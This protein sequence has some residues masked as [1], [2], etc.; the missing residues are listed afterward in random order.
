[1]E[2]RSRGGAVQCRH[3]VVW[4]N[5]ARRRLRPLRL[6]PQDE[7]EY[8]ANGKKVGTRAYERYE[9]YKG[10][11]T[12]EEARQRGALRIDFCHDLRRGYLVIT[13]RAARGTA[14][15]DAVL[16]VATPQQKRKNDQYHHHAPGLPHLRDS[17]RITYRTNRKRPGSLAYDRYEAYRGAKTVAEARQRG[18]SAEDFL[19]DLRSGHLTITELDFRPFS[20]ECTVKDDRATSSTDMPAPA[21]A[22]MASRDAKPVRLSVKGVARVSVTRGMLARLV[23]RSPSLSGVRRWSGRSGPLSGITLEALRSLLHWAVTGFLAFAPP[24]APTL[25]DALLALGVAPDLAQRVLQLDVSQ[26]QTS[27]PKLWSQQIGAP[28]AP[29][30]APVPATEAGGARD[31]GTEAGTVLQPAAPPSGQHH[32]AK[33]R[34]TCLPQLWTAINDATAPQRS[35]VAGEEQSAMVDERPNR[36]HQHDRHS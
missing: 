26:G 15:Q 11:K 13:R 22:T 17:D 34:Q 21:T 4:H 19:H 28:P 23:G 31:G 5:V 10:A 24:A 29:V 36:R 25:H 14:R 30:P 27:L 3:Q 20:A 33:P 2:A 6:H 9:S 16:R 32:A 35:A 12:V 7:I 18:A 1:M 8:K